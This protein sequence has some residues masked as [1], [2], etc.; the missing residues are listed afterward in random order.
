MT[1]PKGKIVIIGSSVATDAPDHWACLFREGLHSI[2]KL[3]YAAMTERGWVVINMAVSGFNTRDT[4]QEFPYVIPEKPNIV[5]V[6]LSL[7][8]EGNIIISYSY[9]IGMV[10]TNERAVKSFLDG[11]RK[12]VDMIKEIGAIP[13]LGSP[14]PN[15]L[16][17]Y[18]I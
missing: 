13:V 15:N 2:G 3:I 18:H 17:P 14:Y 11:M 16:F 12:L 7:A 6:A 8:N 4:I 9:N 1:T 10:G 5:I